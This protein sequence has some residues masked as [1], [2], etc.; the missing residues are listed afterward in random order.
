MGD[1]DFLIVAPGTNR[2]GALRLAERV[3]DTLDEGAAKNEQIGRL[4]LKARFYALS[5]SEPEVVTPEEFLRRAT[6]AFVAE[7]LIIPLQSSMA[8]SRV[9]VDRL[10]ANAILCVAGEGRIARTFYP[11]EFLGQTAMFAPGMAKLSRLSGAPILPTFWVPSGEPWGVV[12]ILPPIDI[13]KSPDHETAVVDS[14][15]QFAAALEERVRRWPEVYRNWH[16]VRPQR[17]ER[18]CAQAPPESAPGLSVL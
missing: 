1:S 18:P 13:A 15:R 5:G 14:I 3:M 2:A 12:E 11:N 10:S 9:Y 6:A 17:A 16:M 7:I 8:Q 4:D